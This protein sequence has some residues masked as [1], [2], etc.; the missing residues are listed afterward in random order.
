MVV[1]TESLS[2][3][4][5]LLVFFSNNG[6]SDL[7]ITAGRAAT[8]KKD[9]KLVSLTEDKLTADTAT[10]LAYQM[11][12]HDQLATFQ[13]TQE[14]N[15]AYHISG[16]ARYRVNIFIQ[17]GTPGMVIRSVH[18]EIPTFEDLNLPSII[19]ETITDKNGLILI[20]GGTGSGK[21]TTLAS[22]VDV[23]NTTMDG[24]IITIEDP[25]EFIHRHKKSI[26]TQREVGVDTES[27]ESALKNTLRQAPDVILIG[28]IRSRDTM[29]HAI[30]FSETGHLCLSTLHANNTNQTLDRIINFFPANQRGHILMDLSLNLKA[31]ISQRLIPKIGGGLIA[32]VEVLINTP[33]IAE[34]IFHGKV[35]EIKQLMQNSSALGMQ[36]F[37]QALFDLYE[38]GLITYQD[39]LRGADSMNDLR[40]NIK[41]NSKLPQPSDDDSELSTEAIKFSLKQEE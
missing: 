30:A 11:M 4:D 19:K 12:N 14:I 34:L 38:N 7:F 41:L 16:I 25:I 22:L 24:H 29:E 2:E 23:R 37:D 26:V 35:N 13:N 31:V 6:G 10:K 9:G 33:R 39:A 17:R 18:T 21:S 3:L 27:Y 20:V 5:K 36:T 8:M 40:L 1:D 15:F 32:A 28:E